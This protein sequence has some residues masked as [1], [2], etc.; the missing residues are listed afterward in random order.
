MVV[1][2][3]YCNVA[4][5]DDV[6]VLSAAIVVRE[7]TLSLILLTLSLL[8]TFMFSS[9]FLFSLIVE[10]ALITGTGVVVV[11]VVLPVFDLN[12]ASK[13]SSITVVGFA[14][15]SF[16]T[17]LL[18]ISTGEFSIFYLKVYFDINIYNNK[19]KQPI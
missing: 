12:K 15:V 17:S 8:S 4:V 18:L 10:V 11:F 7:S 13:K 16:L 14:P 19:I 9:W 2:C 1:I 6:G 3:G 5:V